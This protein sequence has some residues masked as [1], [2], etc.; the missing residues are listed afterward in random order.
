M[1]FIGQIGRNIINTPGN[2][3]NFSKQHLKFS[4]HYKIQHVLMTLVA[5]LKSLLYRR[6]LKQFGYPR[7]NLAQ[8]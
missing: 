3:L 2:L 6:K 8:D 1:P 5:K 7:L 4:G